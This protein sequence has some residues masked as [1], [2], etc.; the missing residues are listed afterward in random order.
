MKLKIETPVPSHQ[1]GVGAIWSLSLI[2]PL[3]VGIGTR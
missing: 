3:Q 2:I 1:I